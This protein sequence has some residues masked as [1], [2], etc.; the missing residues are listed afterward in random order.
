MART[1]FG[2]PLRGILF[3]AA[4]SG[5]VAVLAGLGV[6][7]PG[8]QWWVAL[9]GLAMAAS[10]LFRR[11][12]PSAT[13]VAVGALALLQT[14]F[15]S[16]PRPYDVA[17]LI[18]MYSVVKYARRLRDGL[19]AGA[20]AAVGAVLGAW[21]LPV[22]LWWANALYLALVCGAVWLAALNV[23]TRR[24]YVLSLEERAATLERERDARARAAVVEE[25]AQIARELHDVVAHSLAVMIVQAD[26]AGYTLDRDRDTA[27]GAVR[28]IAETGRQAL[29][30]MRLLVGVLRAAGPPDGD[31]AEPATAGTGRRPPALDELDSLLE[32]SRA[33]GLTVH[34]T[35][36][37]SPGDL[38]TGLALTVYRLAQ[39]ALTNALK[40]SGA[41]ASVDLTLDC[42]ACDAVVLRVVDDGAGRAAGAAPSGGHGL[43][44]MRERVAVYGGSFHAGPRPGG[45]WEVTARL[46]RPPSPRA[47]E[48]VA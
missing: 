34:G 31:R 43:V 9:V 20:G 1:A 25:R 16:G 3:D 5:W 21:A 24:L 27:R 47:E 35:V 19:I 6:L 26:G 39:E 7:A 38:P 17:V 23:R 41:G 10:L 46:P 29:E 18:A 37:G 45:G 30:E 33:A 4:V 32:R 42:R 44:G 12:H 15:G 40:H 14:A 28:A 2:R 22:G 8:Q 13:A 48:Q 36:G 11:A